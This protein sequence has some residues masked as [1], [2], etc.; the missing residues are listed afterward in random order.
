MYLVCCNYNFSVNRRCLHFLADLEINMESPALNVSEAAQSLAVP[1]IRT[2]NL[3]VDVEV[4]CAYIPG[5]TVPG[6]YI[7]N[8]KCTYRQR[9]YKW[10]HCKLLN[11]IVLKSTTTSH[12]GTSSCSQ[13]SEHAHLFDGMTHGIILLNYGL[14]EAKLNV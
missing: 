4:T 6:K 11:M 14:Y 2:G 7:L 13:F 3:D 12:T 9:A 8:P 5:S 1:F 10:Y